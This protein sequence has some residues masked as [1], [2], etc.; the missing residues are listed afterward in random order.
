MKKKEF[1]IPLDQNRIILFANQY[2]VI[3][4]IVFV[5]NQ[6]RRLVTVKYTAFFQTNGLSLLIESPYLDDNSIEIMISSKG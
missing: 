3:N 1:R 2:I 5:F 4:M 6:S